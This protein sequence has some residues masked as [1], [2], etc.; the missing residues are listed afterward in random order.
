LINARDSRSITTAALGAGLEYAWLRNWTVKAEYLFLGL[1]G[2]IRTCGI[3]TTGPRGPFCWDHSL[4][5]IH[6]FKV[7]V[8]YKFGDTPVMARY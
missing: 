1:H 2:T 3:E 7:G 5:G 4:S 8:N 6:T